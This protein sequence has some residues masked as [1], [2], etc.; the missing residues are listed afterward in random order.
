VCLDLPT[1]FLRVMSETLLHM[2]ENCPKTLS[3]TMALRT[4]DWPVR[5]RSGY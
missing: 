4:G 1:F 3:G 2:V 5:A